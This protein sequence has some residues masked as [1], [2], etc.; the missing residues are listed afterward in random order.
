MGMAHTQSRAL[1]GLHTPCVHVEVDLA[2][3]LPSFTLVGLADTEVKEARERVRAAIVNSGLTFPNNQRI[4]VNLAP[5]DLRKD[6]GRF[7]LAIALGILVASGQIPAFDPNQWTFAAELSLSGQLRPV[8]GAL[9]MALNMANEGASGALVLAGEN[10]AEAARVPKLRVASAQHLLDV[11]AHFLQSQVTGTTANAPH[12]SAEQAGWHWPQPPELEVRTLS[13]SLADVRGQDS[14]K[15]ALAI[16]AAG[17][18]SVLLVGP[19]GSGKSM[20]AQRF[21]SLLPPLSEAEALQ[22]AAIQSLMGGFQAEQWGH[23]PMVSPHHSASAAALI[24]GGSPPRPGAITQAHHGILFLDE[25]PEFNR[26][27]LEALREPLETGTI[28]ISRA[29]HHA[30]FPAQFQL[31][32]AMN[33]CPCGYWGHPLRPCRCTPDQVAR[34]Q[35]RISGPLLDRI[36]LQVE[37]SAIDP[38]TLLFDPSRTSP[39]ATQS[40]SATLPSVAQTVAARHLALQRQTCLN[41]ELQGDALLAHAGVVGDDATFLHAAAN[42]LYWSSRRIHRVLRVARTIADLAQHE[43]VTRMHLAEAMQYQRALLN[44]GTT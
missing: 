41:G 10:A 25:L 32:A 29:S 33:P 15:R 37:V 40:A 39:D 23:R 4:T 1:L 20:L 44:T 43:A 30:Q 3:G 36:D 22:S 38:A 34:Y 21:I 11:V 5:A 18:H 7:D 12:D 17:G 8:A 16:A 14:A 27:A 35:A 31:I 26:P 2:N 42:R 9:A 19:P 13:I 28:H 6:S 24:G